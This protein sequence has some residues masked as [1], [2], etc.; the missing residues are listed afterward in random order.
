VTGGA[1]RG[2]V[3]DGGVRD[4]GRGTLAVGGVGKVNGDLVDRIGKGSHDH[5][6]IFVIPITKVAE[7]RD[8]TV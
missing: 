7:F 8:V 1:Q 5:A 2:R 4:L 6:G 3:V